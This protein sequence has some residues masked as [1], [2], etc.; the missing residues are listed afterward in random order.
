MNQSAQHVSDE[1]CCVGCPSVRPSVRP[2]VSCDQ[3]RQAMKEAV[4]HLPPRP[5]PPPREPFMWLSGLEDLVVTKERF[6][7]LNVGERYCTSRL[8]SRRVGSRS[9]LS[10]LPRQAVSPSQTWSAQCVTAST[11]PI[12]KRES[13]RH[14]ATAGRQMTGSRDACF[15]FFFSLSVFVGS[16]APLP[17]ARVRRVDVETSMLGVLAA[18]WDNFGRNGRGALQFLNPVKACPLDAKPDSSVL[19]Y[20]YHIASSAS[21]YL[22]SCINYFRVQTRPAPPRPRPPPHFD[23]FCRG[24]HPFDKTAT[25]AT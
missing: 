13:T 19:T 7:F 21:Y 16:A 25:G 12:R 6:Q 11:A 8:G 18:G 23:F 4:Q 24:I 10:F 14:P 1:G 2:S 15:F 5:L 9:R 3:P 20:P 22:S 17:A